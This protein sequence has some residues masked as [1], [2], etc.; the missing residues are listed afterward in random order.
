MAGPQ[1]S[2]QIEQIKLSKELATKKNRV[3]RALGKALEEA[4]VT[5]STS[6]V[7]ATGLAL[8]QCFETKH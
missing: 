7:L 6:Q 1:R 4:W 5:F 2:H 3:A 8:N